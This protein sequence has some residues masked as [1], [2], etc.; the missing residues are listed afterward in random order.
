MGIGEVLRTTKEMGG[1][2]KLIKYA[3]PQRN[4]AA[5]CLGTQLARNAAEFGDERAL[6]FEGRDIT[7]R[8]YNELANQYANALKADGIG[9]GDTV[10]IMMENRIE[11]LAALIGVN[12]LGATAAL[13]NTGLT[14]TPLIHCVSSVE[15]K[16]VIV[17]TECQQAIAEALQDIPLKAGEDFLV[18]KDK[19]EDSVP[20]W[21]RDF[22]QVASDASKDNPPETE[23]I[24][25][26]SPGLYIFTSGTTG[27]PKAAI[28]SNRRFMGSAVAAGKIGLRCG[29]GDTIYLCLP[30][31]HL[32][33]LMLGF[34][35]GLTSGSTMF[36]RRKFSA[37][38]F[39]PEI[40]EHNCKAMVYIGEM[41]RYLMSSP[42]KPDD[43]DNPLKNIMGNG[44]RPDIW[45]DFKQRFGIERIAEFYGSSEGN[46]AFLNLLNKDKTIGFCPA[47]YAVVKYD[48]DNDEIVRDANGRCI[49]AGKG[50]AGLLMGKITE[51]T[52][53]E[54]Y[55]SKEATEKKIVR[56]AFEEGDAWFNTGDLIK[57]VDV[58]FAFGIPHF[59]FVDRVGD[60]FRWRSEN[61]STNE[62]GEII[63]QHP[64][65]EIT[66]V[67]GV[68]IP[69]TEGRA[70]MASLVLK[71]DAGD[72]D[73]D[74][75]AQ[76]V[77]KELPAFARPV[78]VRIQ[79]E[80][81]VT[82]TFKLLKGDLRKEV[83]DIDAVSDP[84]YVM[85]PGS[86]QYEKLDQD[87]Y[88]KLKDGSAGF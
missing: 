58:G 57:R 10:C 34:G 81:Q 42:E 56:N 52:K 16:K 51:K 76:F 4:D 13:I 75:F 1:L 45:I 82:G 46:V 88:Q 27:L 33:G 23:Q 39:L 55:T 31:Y 61:V 5:N 86:Q 38:N 66:N 20:D 2:L 36:I 74:E 63:N 70:G 85:K 67:Y 48:V 83:Y 25:P 37:S 29:R 17:G 30:L 80:L 14:G 24:D 73:M 40:R 79:R 49:K 77:N 71:E 65:I 47:P 41:C 59:Q 68:E 11:F 19:A 43:A 6:I 26:Q 21:A 62:V 72:L 53:F 22:D 54:G 3:N 87:F 12:K 35:G 32:T 8:A 60:T 44:L 78:F 50:E 69:G 9:S 84:I 15:S 64:K 7:W 18:I 28:V